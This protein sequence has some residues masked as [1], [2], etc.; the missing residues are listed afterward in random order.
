MVTAM[1]NMGTVT[2]SMAM[3]STMESTHMLLITVM[4]TKKKAIT[5]KTS[6]TEWN[7]CFI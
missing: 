5:L 6:T 1:E 4:V 7:R 2:E 3:L